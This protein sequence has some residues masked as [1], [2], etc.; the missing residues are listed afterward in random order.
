ML[1]AA[2]SFAKAPSLGLSKPK[3]LGNNEPTAKPLAA[4]KG[5]AH[6]LNVVVVEGWV[7]SGGGVAEA[8]VV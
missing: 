7:V 4:V 5:K 2:K 6:G 3:G 8:K 1:R